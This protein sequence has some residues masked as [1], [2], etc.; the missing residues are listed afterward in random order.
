MVDAILSFWA[1]NHAVS[2]GSWTLRGKRYLPSSA[3]MSLQ[4]PW[5]ASVTLTDGRE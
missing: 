2:Q 5:L 4:E 1:A 3:Y